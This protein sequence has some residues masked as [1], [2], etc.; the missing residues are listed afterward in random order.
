M[1]TRLNGIVCRSTALLAL[2]GALV[3]PTA[4]AQGRQPLR[5]TFPT[6]VA[7]L[8]D[9]IIEDWQVG[10]VV[11]AATN[12]KRLVLKVTVKNDGDAA[13]S[14][15]LTRITVTNFLATGTGPRADTRTF[16]LDTSALGVGAA[17]TLTVP[18]FDPADFHFEV[19]VDAG[20]A[21]H[22]KFENNNFL[23]I[24]VSRS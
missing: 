21:I 8:P 19:T 5:P 6:L 16:D 24:G 4:H 22:E 14:A 18:L 13:A 10:S 23:S 15:S 7:K 11:D 20:H 2:A 3:A 12:R 9:L 1:V 17:A